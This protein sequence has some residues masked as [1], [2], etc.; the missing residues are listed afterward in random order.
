MRGQPVENVAR[1]F[2]PWVWWSVL[3]LLLSGSILIVGEPERSLTNPTFQL[4]MGMLLTVLVLTA[5]FQSGLRRDPQYWE[6]TMPRLASVRLIAG[7]SLLLWIGIVF[8]G[9]WIAYSI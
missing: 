2:L 6:R 8:A 3:V 9:R 7:T 1:R 4:K 5:T